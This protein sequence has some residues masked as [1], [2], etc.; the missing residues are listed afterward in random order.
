VLDFGQYFEIEN[1][2]KRIEPIEIV[3]NEFGFEPLICLSAG[4]GLENYNPFI[5][6][7]PGELIA[8]LYEEYGPRLLEQNVRTFLQVK[9]KANKEMLSTI[10]NAPEMFF[11]YNNGLT[12]TASDLT[13]DE[14]KSGN[15]RITAIK[16]LQIVN[17]GQ[18]TATI[19]YAKDKKYDLSKVIVQM[20]L[21]SISDTERME[22]FVPK[23]SRFANTQTKIQDSDFFSN[24]AFH[25]EMERL[26]RRLRVHPKEE[27]FDGDKWFYERAKGQY[28]E[29]KRRSPN[30]NTFIKNF[31]QSQLF[32]KTDLSKYFMSFECKPDIVSKGAQFH[33]KKFAELIEPK[34]DKNKDDINEMWYKE[35]IAK[36]IIFKELDKAVLAAKVGEL[37]KN[38]TN[39]YDGDY[40]ANIVTY[41]IAKLV[42]IIKEKSERELDLLKVWEEQT[43]SGNLLEV[44]IEIAKQVQ[45]LIQDTPEGQKNV[46]QYCKQPACWKRISDADFKVEEILDSC[47]RSSSGAQAERKES[48]KL[49]KSDDKLLGE[50]YFIA[51][52]D[53]EWRRVLDFSRKNNIYT[54]HIERTMKKLKSYSG[55]VKKSELEELNKHMNLIKANHFESQFKLEE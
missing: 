27:S 37:G 1:A 52:P 38:D 11:A 33:F 16:G 9:I 13:I 44:L 15:K 46:T 47:L 14:D 18:T 19:S 5:V 12:A 20:K 35:I 28:K 45:D 17:G 25:R 6:V 36:A 53:E 39:W 49:Q 40:K 32:Q 23:I 30:Q 43:A 42:S 2:D 41:S 21:T 26:S 31:P 34:W 50:G 7:L 48:K 51:M 8:K 29:E 10:Q 55:S 54:A 4:S 22:E 3:L 24:H